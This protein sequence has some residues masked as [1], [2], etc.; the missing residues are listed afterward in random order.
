MNSPNPLSQEESST[1]SLGEEPNTPTESLHDPNIQAIAGVILGFFSAL[2]FLL[3]ECGLKFLLSWVTLAPWLVTLLYVINLFFLIFVC[4][5][6]LWSFHRKQQNKGV[7][8]TKVITL[9]SILLITPLL[10]FQF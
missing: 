3:I 6:I 5:V 10:W 4:L 2:P 1:H 9:L 8:I 7:V